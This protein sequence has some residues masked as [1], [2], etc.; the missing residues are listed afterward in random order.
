MLASGLGVN[1]LV[2]WTALSLCLASVAWVFH[3]QTQVS[4]DTVWNAIGTLGKVPW[5]DRRSIP[6][7][8]LWSSRDRMTLRTCAEIVTDNNKNV[9][10]STERIHP[11]TPHR[12]QIARQ[13]GQAAKSHDLPLAGVFLAG[14]LLLLLGGSELFG[15]LADCVR[16]QLSGESYRLP[17]DASM[18]SSRRHD[19]LLRLGTQPGSCLRRVAVQ[20]PSLSHLLQT[21]FQP[22]P[23]R[24]APDFSRLDPS[25]DGRAD[26]LR[27]HGGAAAAERC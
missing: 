18:A 23:Q 1:S 3:D 4:L 7:V 24:L 10:E 12:R 14:V 26:V 6:D 16:Q 9:R 20:W 15:T 5:R 8:I 19:A 27:R 2:A 22:Q 11:P 13:Q 25:G 21:G 17:T